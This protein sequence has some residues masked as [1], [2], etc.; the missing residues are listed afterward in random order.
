MKNAILILTFFIVTFGCG[1]EEKGKSNGSVKTE[2]GEEE[3]AEPNGLVKPVSGPSEMRGEWTLE[4]VTMKENISYP[5]STTG[6]LTAKFRGNDTFY[7]TYESFSLSG[8]ET[9]LYSSC[10]AFG[11]GKFRIE[12]GTAILSDHQLGLV[13]GNCDGVTD[14]PGIFPLLDTAVKIETHE[15][16]LLISREFS[17]LD[18]VGNPGKDSLVYRF[19][20]TSE[21]TWGGAGF[22]PAFDGTW[23]SSKIYMRTNCENK[24]FAPVIASKSEIPISGIYTK[25]ISP[26]E[27]AEES[28]EFSWGDGEKCTGTASGTVTPDL[29][30]LKFV[31]VAASTECTKEGEKSEGLV[32][33][34]ERLQ[35]SGTNKLV[36]LGAVTYPNDGCVG[37]K[38][39]IQFIGISEK[40]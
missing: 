15:G 31:Q 13:S 17:Y 34:L 38:A 6:F 23:K 39:G 12:N 10:S 19:N 4:T 11:S 27:Y 18:K 30:D 35:I 40:Q 33:L 8:G 37:E 28:I 25:K 16:K 36:Q 32:V 2:S 7:F 29:L 14:G 1:K 9:S 22:D 21:E 20:R 3:K 26:L 5:I 24:I